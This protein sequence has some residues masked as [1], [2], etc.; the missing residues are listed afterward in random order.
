MTLKESKVTSASNDPVTLYARLVVSG[1]IVA[2]RLVRLACQRH[3]DDLKRQGKKGYPYRFSTK[4]AALVYQFFADFLTLDDG[5]PFVLMNW[6]MFVLGSLEGWI[7]RAGRQRFQTS[8]VETSKGSA[9]S[10]IAAGY[11]LFCLAGKNETSA[12]IY[13]LGVDAAQAGYLYKFAKRM[14]DRS[15]DLKQVLNVGEHNIAWVDRQSYFRPLSAEGRSLDNKRPY[16]AIVDEL[17]EHP[18]AV[19]PEKMR[20]G[21]KG[22]ADA[23]LF[24][25]T[26]A[27]H[28][29]SSVCWEHHDYTVRVLEG[30]VTGTAADRW[31]GY[32]CQ[33]DP[34]EPCREAGY[35]A[36]NDGCDDCDHWTDPAVWPKVQPSLGVTIT[37]EQ[38]QA[39]VDEAIARPSTQART[40]RL[41]FCIW[42]QAHTVWIPSDKWSAC[43][44]PALVPPSR[45]QNVAMGFDM[46]EKL[47]LTSGVV[48]I[49]IPDDADRASDVVTLDDTA[50]G[51]PISKTLNINFTVELEPFF[52]LPAD[53][54]IDRV[55]SEHIP[56]N[57]WRD[58]G[59][60]RVT[61]GGVIDYDQIYD[62]L[63]NDILPAF[64]PQ[65]IGY[66][67][68]N[69]TQFAVALR[70]RAKQTMVE[71]KQGRALSESFKLF[72]AL[73]YLGRIRH[74]GSPILGWC[75][76]NA[77]PKRDRYENM[78]IEKPSK[79]K[80]IDG[81]IAAVIA[82]SQL[83][84]L[85]SD[86][87]SVASRDFAER[88]LFV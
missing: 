74:R 79:T 44:V 33:L 58:D 16:L 55:K 13:S 63:V 80:R 52:W 60:L 76:A 72:E 39:L 42:T 30:T 43:R 35:T 11:G 10:P 12:E 29:K 24:E 46:S 78:W 38:M 48:A 49:Q 68:H 66:D 37:V 14:A 61:P 64:R 57:L 82:L 21:F 22:R 59:W 7:D 75:L 50:N 47:D 69:A 32:I 88:G 73:V 6:A 65:R 70:D 41:M 34:C 56:F 25:I 71:A 1:E 3:L 17:H 26:N 87:S 85:Q 53:T 86:P 27:G 19:I 51:Q 28:D 9:K 45:R 36:P 5:R 18:S 31:F 81:V 54:L 4:R 83:V 20:L 15:D 77:N 2:G 84:L 62:E 67:P 23:L 8:Y 40:K